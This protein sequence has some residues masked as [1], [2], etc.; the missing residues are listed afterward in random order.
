MDDLLVILVQHILQFVQLNMIESMLNRHAIDFDRLVNL[1]EFEKV[2]RDYT[3]QVKPI[4]I[5]TVDGGP[6][7]NPRFP[8]TLVASYKKI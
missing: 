1:K 5:I 7:E 6:D 8:K 2:A 3:G 4:V